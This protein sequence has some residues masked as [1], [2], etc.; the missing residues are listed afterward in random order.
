[1]ESLKR[2]F[3]VMAV[4]V[5]LLASLTNCVIVPVDPVPAGYVMSPPYV[6]VR[7][8]YPYRAYYGRYP[9]GYRR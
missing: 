4:G 1:M 6:A 2:W 5:T 9:Y 8:Y 3:V 7:P